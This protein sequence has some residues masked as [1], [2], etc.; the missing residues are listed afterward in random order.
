MESPPDELK[1]AAQ[2]TQAEAA[3]TLEDVPAAHRV[4]AAP[5][6]DTKPDPQGEHAEAAAVEV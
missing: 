4:Q 6:A 1:P 5:A 3:A 2:G